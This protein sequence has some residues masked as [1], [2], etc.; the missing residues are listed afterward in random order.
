MHCGRHSGAPK[1]PPSSLTLTSVAEVTRPMPV[2]PASLE[3]QRFL[4][5]AFK[6]IWFHS[7]L[8]F[9]C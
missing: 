5:G 8:L 7:L 2:R 6:V 1:A 3:N 4:E 9:G